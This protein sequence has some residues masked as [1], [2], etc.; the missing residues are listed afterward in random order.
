MW[1]FLSKLQVLLF[2]EGGGSIY[3]TRI[4][5]FTETIREYYTVTQI[6]YMNAQLNMFIEIKEFEVSKL[7][8]KK[9]MFSPILLETCDPTGAQADLFGTKVGCLATSPSSSMEMANW[10]RSA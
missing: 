2:S 1:P 4:H 5:T 6:L 7:L 9:V 8:Q 10:S 3:S